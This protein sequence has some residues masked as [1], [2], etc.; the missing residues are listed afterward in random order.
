MTL[1]RSRAP[2][3]ATTTGVPARPSCPVA[4]TRTVPPLMS[5]PLVKVAEPDGRPRSGCVSVTWDPRTLATRVPGAMP[6]PATSMPA[7][8]LA[9]LV[10]LS[11]RSPG[12]LPATT[13]V[14]TLRP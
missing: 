12:L 6:L 7:W 8:R 13:A 4:P 14:E 3:L 10:T 5:S 9:V 11:A 1:E 2:P